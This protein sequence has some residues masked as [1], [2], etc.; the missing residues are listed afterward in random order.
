MRA[1]EVMPAGAP[2]GRYEIVSLLSAMGLLGQPE[3][4]MALMRAS[5]AIQRRQCRARPPLTARPARR[6]ATR[7][8]PARWSRGR[9]CRGAGVFAQE[10]R[11]LG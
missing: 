9:T 3:E 4:G 1:T 10:S 5:I 11:Y 8:R 6:S 7:G 2:V